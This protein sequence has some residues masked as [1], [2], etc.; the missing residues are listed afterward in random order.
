M[1]RKRRLESYRKRIKALEGRIRVAQIELDDIRKKATFLQAELA[2]E[3]MPDWQRNALV[4]SGMST[5][6]QPRQPVCNES[7]L[8]Y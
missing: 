5:N 7:D 1:T 8:S 2:V 6:P 4:Y 3:A